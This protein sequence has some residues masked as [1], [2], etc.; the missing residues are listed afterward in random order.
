[1]DSQSEQILK[2]LQAGNALT[3]LEVLR[4]F[5]CLRLAARIYYL[6]QSG[7]QINSSLITDEH[8]KSVMPVIALFEL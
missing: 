7:Y 3:F 4:K 1:M 5:N 6:R 8:E 2:Y